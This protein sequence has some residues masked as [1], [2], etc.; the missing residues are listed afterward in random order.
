MPEAFIDLSVRV[1]RNDGASTY[2]DGIQKA[3]TKRLLAIPEPRTPIRINDPVAGPK[4]LWEVRRQRTG[5]TVKRTITNKNLAELRRVDPGL[6]ARAVR[7]KSADKRF[8]M[9]YDYRATGWVNIKAAGAEAAREAW[10]GRTT[11]KNWEDPRVLAETIRGL[12]R[13]VAA[14]KED[15]KNM[16]REMSHLLEG[17]GI[18][19]GPLMVPQHGHISVREYHPGYEKDWNLLVA[20]PVA[21]RLIT[22]TEVPGYT[23]V[24]FADLSAEVDPEGDEDEEGWA[25]RMGFDL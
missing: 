18:G 15:D 24:I 21:E 5:V 8:S 3:L 7:E 2:L 22:V 9:Y 20:S 17:G 12:R 13:E 6:Y 4:R 1:K 23:K 16:R 19:T 10:A 14:R 11:G 25:A